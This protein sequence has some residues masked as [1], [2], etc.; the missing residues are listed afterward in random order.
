MPIPID[1]Q[2]RFIS[3]LG[4]QLLFRHMEG[5]EA[6]GRP[7]KYDLTLLSATGTSEATLTATGAVKTS[8]AGV[9]ATGPKIDITGSV[10]VNVTGAMVKIN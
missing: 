6:L 3:P 1:A 9:E 7:F 4:D 2:V 5:Q 8:P 10:A